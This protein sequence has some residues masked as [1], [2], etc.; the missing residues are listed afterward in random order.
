ME[1]NGSGG[2]LITVEQRHQVLTR[3]VV[4]KLAQPGR[5]RVETHGD[6]DAVLVWGRR[7]N[8]LLHF[9]IFLIFDVWLLPWMLITLVSHERR[10]LMEV[11]DTGEVTL[12]QI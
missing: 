4:A 12:R 5:W 7:P 8:H 11:D 3:A 1:A 10:Y 2:S 9:V 6:H